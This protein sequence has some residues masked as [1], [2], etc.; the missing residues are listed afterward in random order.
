MTPGRSLPPNANARSSAPA[1]TMMRRARANH[2][3]W[4]GRRGS[5]AARWS[6]TRSSRPATPPSYRP[7]AVVRVI[8]RTPAARASSSSAVRNC[9]DSAGGRFNKSPPS[10]KSC[11]TN[12]TSRPARAAVAAAARPAGPP[13]M[14]N[15]SQNACACSYWSGS[16]AREAAPKPAARRMNCSHTNHTVVPRNH[17]GPMKVL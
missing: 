6:V 16:G 2:N 17:R 1:A 4:R 14:T 3:R 13:P 5:G 15:T 9:C 7:K 12:S 10:S 11:S 8:N